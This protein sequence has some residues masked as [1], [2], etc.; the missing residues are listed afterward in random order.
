MSS[1]P[2]VAAY[3]MVLIEDDCIVPEPARQVP[4]SEGSL[5][6]SVRST[7]ARCISPTGMTA[8]SE[9]IV[10]CCSPAALAVCQHRPEFGITCLFREGGIGLP[11]GRVGHLVAD[12]LIKGLPAR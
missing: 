6:R 3:P 10:A 11:H 12:L 5:S 9:L 1:T 4:L 2:V 7:M 8:P